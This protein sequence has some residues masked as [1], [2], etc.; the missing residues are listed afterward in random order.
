LPKP[1]LLCH[2]K[3][4]IKHTRQASTVYRFRAGFSDCPVRLVH[5]VEGVQINGHDFRR[6]LGKQGLN[7]GLQL[8]VI[9]CRMQVVFNFI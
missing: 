5:V 6:M 4:N 3:I 2:Q 8:R 7:G 9:H 1:T